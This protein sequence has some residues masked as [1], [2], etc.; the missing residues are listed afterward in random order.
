MN[1]IKIL[2]I[3]DEYMVCKN[4]KIFLTDEGFDVY[5]ASSG[6]EAIDFLK[7]EKVDIC[8]VDMRL[9]KMDG[10]TLILES[11]K[12]FPDLKYIIHTGST[13]YSPPKSILDLGITED[14][15][16]KKP[17]KDMKILINAIKTIS[18][19]PNE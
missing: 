18:G 8:I 14:L 3:D 5:T 1:N 11:N 16:L 15:I 19:K 17:I 13:N 7:K 9:Q 6:E 2:I 10:N 4:L 12:I